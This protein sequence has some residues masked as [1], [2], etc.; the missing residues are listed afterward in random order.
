MKLIRVAILI[1][2]ILSASVFCYGQTN[3][4]IQGK[5]DRGLRLFEDG[6]LLESIPYFEEVYEVIPG[7]LAVRK[8]LIVALKY[9]GIEYYTLN[10]ND[11]AIET[12]QKG[13]QIDP[14]NKEIASFI[15]RVNSEI[16]MLNLKSDTNIQYEEK[17]V[18][19]KPPVSKPPLTDTVIVNNYIK[20]PDKQAETSIHSDYR[21]PFIFGT[22]A[23]MI[24]SAG[25]ET[26]LQ[27]AG[28]TFS[29]N[30]LMPL[31]NDFAGLQLEGMYIKLDPDK[32]ISDDDNLK[33]YYGIFGGRANMLWKFRVSGVSS[34]K[35]AG[36]IGFYQSLHSWYDKDGEK[37][38]LDRETG[39]GFNVGMGWQI[40]FNK[41]AA[42]INFGY[43]YIDVPIEPRLV[44]ISIS[45]NSH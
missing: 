29:G 44:E 28:W 37:G 8:Y 36:G 7:Y 15:D 20:V 42:S 10:R 12:W 4:S 21:R 27:K 35:L 31:K 5:Y 9:G 25:D 45:L 14:G 41:F 39:L 17:P 13:L 38:G 2:S 24:F 1:F 33:E 40:D 11:E 34:F 43:S 23:G 16:K 3:Q 22:S 6:R 30:I 19:K 18:R 32:P 26:D